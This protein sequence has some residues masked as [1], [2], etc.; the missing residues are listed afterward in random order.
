MTER[1]DG[2]VAVVTGAG[3]GVGRGIALVLARHGAAVVLGGRTVSKLDSVRE[4]IAA[5][6]GRAASV[7]CDVSVR[8]D[9]DALVATTV[10]TFG[11]P[12]ILVNNAQG[13]GNT[14][15]VDGAALEAVTEEAMLDLF[16]GGVLASLY[17]MQACFPHMKTRGGTIVNLGSR[18][19]VEGT[20]GATP[21]G[22]AKEAIRGLT[23]HAA[24]EWG[25]YGISVNVICPAALS[26][27]A[28]QFRDADPERWEKIVASIP[29]GYMGDP[30]DDI[31][32]TVVAL[33]TDLHYL[34]GATLMLDG[35]MCILR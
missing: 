23:K 24:R 20:P 30:V 8:A 11:P 32:P 34:T 35:G 9:V 28:A 14:P 25:R 10:E 2:R 6:G 31:G 19:G 26:T 17:G 18:R 7:R 1:L 5:G 3:E 33:A 13:R 21:Y 27:G 15:T 29:L 16:R 22:T 12:D 4:E